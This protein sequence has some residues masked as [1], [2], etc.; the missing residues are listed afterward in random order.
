MSTTELKVLTLNCWGLKWLSTDIEPRIHGIAE[1]IAA[2]NY[3]IVAFQE[4]WQHV[5][6]DHMRT[7]LAK[8]LPYG[9]MFFGGA[10]G[11]GL[12]IFSKYPIVESFTRSYPLNGS[13]L[14]VAA[15]DWFVGKAVGSV[16]LSHPTLGEVEVFTTH[17]YA[18]GGE[19]GP[20]DKRAHR[21]VQSWVLANLLRASAGGRGRHVLLTGDLNSVPTALSINLL[22][23]HAGL[24]DAFVH[25]H[26]QAGASNLH[27]TPYSLQSAEL[28][29]R[30]LGITA[31]SPL[32]TYSAKKKLDASARRWQGKRL[33]YIYY[34]S[35]RMSCVASQVVLT[36]KVPGF[37]FSYSDHFG[38]EATFALLPS[39]APDVPNPP[40]Q[41]LTARTLSQALQALSTFYR[42]S[43]STAR[44]YMTG[45]NGCIL[46]LLALI[47]GSAFQPNRRVNPLLVIL[48]SAFTWG[49]TTLLYAGFVYGKWEQRA[50][51]T[52][53]EEMELEMRR[54]EGGGRG[55][56][57]SPSENSQESGEPLIRNGAGAA[58]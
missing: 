44:M 23:S 24:T 36:D 20:E 43:R 10:L 8:S 25:T 21:I 46:A 7:R 15:G 1:F 39:P 26:P 5:H 42:Q 2:Q 58:V 30:D 49:G 4:L 27:Q 38:L 11:A 33:D 40:V 57:V 22:S 54:V 16:V 34:R 37:D 56:V 12:A 51:M 32:N 29:I 48:A 3:D 35:E 41:P 13:P 17:M 31:D 18:S 45:F 53:I 55:S 50:L 6:Y 9:Q 47:I 28:A 52:V 19:D 14:A